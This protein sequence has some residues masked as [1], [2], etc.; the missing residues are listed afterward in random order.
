MG[1]STADLDPVAEEVEPDRL[2]PLL[3]LLVEYAAA[4]GLA[5]DVAD[6][7]TRISE[8]VG[9]LRS[10]AYLDRG[11]VQVVD[12]HEGLDSTLVLLRS[13]LARMAVERHYTQGL[14][15]VEARGTELNQVWTNLI[16]NA[17]AAT[18]G[19]GRLVVRTRAE[20]GRVV[21]ALE[22]DGPGIAK[23]VI[24]RVFDP[25]FTTKRPGS[26]TGLGLSISHSMVA[27]HG[28]ALTVTS[29]PG[30][31]TFRVEIPAVGGR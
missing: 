8:I 21:V 4:R 1:A 3:S 26:G 20:G 15:K 31:T 30:R 22:D 25:V 6:G 9:A 12:V 14:P 29:E 5:D 7:S 10:Y 16:D 2:P 13:H 23:G 17:V 24:D 19:A 18:E 27:E 11:S 28:G